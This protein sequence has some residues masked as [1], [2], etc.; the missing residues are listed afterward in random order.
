MRLIKDKYEEYIKPL[1]KQFLEE[2]DNAGENYFS[3]ITD[4]MLFSINRQDKRI[5]ETISR[6]MYSAFNKER[7]LHE[8]AAVEYPDEYYDAVYKATQEL[9]PRNDNKLTLLGDRISSLIWLF[10]E[11]PDTKI[12]E[13]TYDW[14]WRTLRVPIE[15]G[16]DDMVVNY[17]STAHQYYSYHLHKIMP[18]YSDKWVV[19]NQKDIDIREK[20]RNR[21]LEFHY[22][23]G[24]LLLYKKR[25][26][27]LF[28][29]FNYTTSIPP[30]YSPLPKMMNEIFENYF[31]FRNPFEFNIGSIS[32]KYSF[33]NIE[34][35][36]AD[37]QIKNWISKYIVLLFIRQ[38]SL[39]SHL[40]IENP[41]EYPKLPEK[42]REK[43]FWLL[44]M[45][46]FEKLTS[47]LLSDKALMSD[48]GLDF[49]N[50]KWCKDNQKPSPIEFIN[51]L[52]EKLSLSIKNTLI[53]QE[54][55]ERKRAKFYE[56][57]KK[58]LVKAFSDYKV[59]NN[60]SYNP[61]IE[62][63]PYYS[64]GIIQIFNKS[65]YADYQETDNV[66]YDSFL[67]EGLA[68]KFKMEISETF[69]HN[70]SVDYI[71]REEDIFKGI[72]KLYLDEKNFVI[73]S[74]RQNIEYYI[75]Q[76]NVAGLDKESY[77][78]IK[79]INFD[80]CNYPF[81]SGSFFILRRE[82]LPFIEF[83]SIEKEEIE[84]YNLTL[85]DNNYNI[86]SNIL[87]LNKPEYKELG[88]ELSKM[89][90]GEDIEKYVLAIILYKAVIK[91]KK[92]INCV[93][94]KAYSKYYQQG[95]PNTLDDIRK[96]D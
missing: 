89:K 52:K 5:E 48:V 16:N 77:K 53:N 65:D 41:L 28:R 49:I 22:A 69:Y 76:Y 12:H 62:F 20:E 79:I 54:V 59:I 82:D 51:E 33:P 87:D 74:F 40:T 23:L 26:N 44:Y 95:L 67:A 25:Y 72:D 68:E 58:I 91:W 63:N 45:D 78:N 64:S 17:W 80:V 70:K 83:E 37:P 36:Q 85:I 21:F 47:E 66:D 2:K 50:E 32:R 6:F 42:Q 90:P 96:F 94:I 55:S 38:W 88:I 10:G 60:E 61:R 13:T 43:S 71:I 39:Y 86:Y 92:N 14:F 9:A 30:D 75:K 73:I 57:S 24:G 56:T 31:Y 8:N 4:L 7:E 3:V 35:V 81:V 27:C 29:I 84:K 1:K 19:T 34:G 18:E 15:Y 93:Q 11:Y 46:F